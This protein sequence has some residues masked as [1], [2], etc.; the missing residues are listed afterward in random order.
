MPARRYGSRVR[1]LQDLMLLG[2]ET[3]TIWLQ[4]FTRLTFWCAL[5]LTGALLGLFGSAALGSTN[6]TLALVVF[7]LGVLTKIVCLIMMLHSARE[8]LQS[9]SQLGRIKPVGVPETV[10]QPSTALTTL[11]A[12]T[13]PFLLTYALWGLVEQEITHLFGMNIVFH[14]AATEHWSIGMNRWPTFLGIAIVLLVLKQSVQ[15]VSD[16]WIKHPRRRT[17][18]SIIVLGMEGMW[19]FA[20]F[21]VATSLWSL[22][23]PWI[24][25]R[26]IVVRAMDAWYTLL[27]AIPSIDLPF[28]LTI[29]QLLLESGPWVMEVFL[30]AMA[31]YVALP[32]FWLALT[33]VVHGWREFHVHDVVTGRP[34]RHLSRMESGLLGVLTKDIR[35]KYLPVLACLRLVVRSGPYFVGAYLILAAIGQFTQANLAWTLH[36]LIGP[37]N[38]TILISV[39]QFVDQTA[40][41]IMLPLLSALY[42]TAFDR[43]VSNTT[44]AHWQRRP[45]STR[46]STTNDAGTSPVTRSQLPQSQTSRGRSSRSWDSTVTTGRISSPDPGSPNTLVGTIHT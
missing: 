11:L 44:G 6:M 28:G 23:F 15:F 34:G 27:D 43:A 2:S 37:R 7:V 26:S 22:A 12:A 9:P 30:P 32:L 33:A 39:A 4:A 19:V 18:L 31:D 17:V 1:L 20:A 35:E 25:R 3:I 5:G 10:F 46:K 36:Q 14:G 21:A 40:E 42:L 41:L 8:A 16:R 13:G 29:D 24:M 45:L 38:D